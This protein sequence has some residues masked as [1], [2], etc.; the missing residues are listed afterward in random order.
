LLNIPASVQNRFDGVE[1]SP[2]SMRASPIQY[3]QN[4]LT[5]HAAHSGMSGTLNERILIISCEW[6]QIS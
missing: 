6:Y 3:V 5:E 2:A 4:F 1:M